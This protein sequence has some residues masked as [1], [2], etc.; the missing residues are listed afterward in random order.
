MSNYP[1]VRPSMTL[2]FEKSKQLDPRVSFSRSSAATYIEGGLVKYATAD[3][4]RF[5]DKGLLVEESRTNEIPYSEDFTHSSWTNVNVTVTSN[6][7]TAPDGTLNAADRL[8]IGDTNG[9]IYNNTVGGVASNS[10]I[11]MWV[12]AVNPGTDDVFRLASAGDLSAD[13]TATNEWVRYTFTSSTTTSSLHGIARPSDNT[14]ADV[15]VWGAQFEEGKTFPTSYIPTSGLTV[16]RSIDIVQITDNNFTSL[17]TPNAGAWIVKGGPTYNVVTNSSLVRVDANSSA[18]A[19]TM[20]VKPTDSRLQFAIK[21]TSTTSG[22]I[23][24]TV[25]NTNSTQALAWDTDI[26]STVNII[27]TQKKLNLYT[28]TPRTLNPLINKFSIGSYRESFNV[29]NGHI[30]RVAYYEQRLTASE[31]QTLTL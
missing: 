1:T 23:A 6:N 7:T 5:E 20:N 24:N 12:K 8:Q 25:V 28:E 31:L 27:I 19:M 3:Q 2:D 17:W 13:L 15:Y 29:L 11:S 10:T 22:D 4:A 9:I 21:D 14:A 30:S 18:Y 16:T 26:D